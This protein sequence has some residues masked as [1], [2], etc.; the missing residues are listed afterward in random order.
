MSLVSRSPAWERLFGI[1]LKVVPESP[2]QAGFG[3]LPK[4][5]IVE[6]TFA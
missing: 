2:E 6:G 5:W 3:V 4:R 1:K